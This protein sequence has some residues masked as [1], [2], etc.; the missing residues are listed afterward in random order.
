MNSSHI[1][2]CFSAETHR[3]SCELF[4]GCFDIRAAIV[5]P[6]RQ[7][8]VAGWVWTD[9]GSTLVRSEAY[10]Y[11]EVHIWW[12]S[13]ASRRHG[14]ERPITHI[15]NSYIRCYQPLLKRATF[16]THIQSP[17]ASEATTNLNAKFYCCKT[18]LRHKILFCALF[19]SRS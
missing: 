16:I 3:P 18:V 15:G 13:L 14:R 19:L 12:R 17:F 7:S 2:T 5:S 6:Q 4:K 10:I 9:G 11:M 8:S 1:C